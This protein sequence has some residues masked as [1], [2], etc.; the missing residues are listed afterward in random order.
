[1]TTWSSPP[2][3]GSRSTERPT[4][5]RLVGRLV[6]WIALLLGFALSG[7]TFKL[8]PPDVEPLPPPVPVVTDIN[9]DLVPADFEFCASRM[10]DGAI[11]TGS[12]NCITA[13]ELR[14]LLRS[15]KRL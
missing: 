12:Q 3:G 14:A 2:A 8:A 10:I 4:R 5:A 11:D 1:M 7:C 9:I 13:E 15:L 6:G